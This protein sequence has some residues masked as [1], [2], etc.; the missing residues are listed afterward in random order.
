MTVVQRNEAPVIVSEFRYE[1]HR[2]EDPR[3]VKID[4]EYYL[5]YTAF[6]RVNV[7]G[8]IATSTDLIHWK[9][10]GIP[11]PQI[12]YARFVELTKS[13]PLNEKY[14]RYNNH[15]GILIKEGKQVLLWDK[16]II[17]FLEEATEM[18]FSCTG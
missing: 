7:L 9:K 16:N 17:F 6:D 18:Y 3:I 2:V 12:T 15:E 14:C 4:K 10:H 5:S 8:A 11:V 13:I 1:S